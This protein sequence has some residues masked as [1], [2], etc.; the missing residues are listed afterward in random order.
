MDDMFDDLPKFLA[1]LFVAGIIFG[2][3]ATLG[4]VWLVHR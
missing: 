1:G 3:F 2:I 4:V